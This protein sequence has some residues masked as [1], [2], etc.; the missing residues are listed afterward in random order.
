MRDEPEAIK[1]LYDL[2]RK[3]PPYSL[4]N[5]FIPD[6]ILNKPTKQF[7]PDEI[8]NPVQEISVQLLPPQKP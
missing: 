1:I 6:P 7:V 3:R 2:A 4:S 5:K 8:I